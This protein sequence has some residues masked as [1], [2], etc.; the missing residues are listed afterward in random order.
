MKKSEALHKKIIIIGAGSA[1]LSAQSYIKHQTSDYLIIDKGPLGTTC[2]RVGC[3]PSKSLIEA[4]KIFYKKKD[5]KKIGI[6]NSIKLKLNS[7]K[8]FDHVRQL[9]DYFSSGV[10]KQTLE[11]PQKNFI[12][13]DAIFLDTRTIK[14]K[15]KTYT[16]DKFIIASGSNAFIPDEW[17]HLKKDLL[18]SDDIFKLKTLP[19]TL[20]VV[21]AGPIGLEL[22]LALSYLGVKVTVYGSHRSLGGL[23]DPFLMS[24]AKKIFQKN[25]RLMDEEVSGIKKNSQHKI[26]IKTQNNSKTFDKVLIA[27]GRKPNL[28]LLEN[29]NLPLKND[30]PVINDLTGQIKNTNLYIAGDMSGLHPLLHEAS[31]DGIRAAKNALSQKPVKIKRPVPL[32]IT[33]TN[34]QIAIIGSSYKELAT[35]KLDFE[36]VESSFEDQG[37]SRTQFENEGHIRIYYKRT[38]LQILGAELF[39]HKAEHLAHFLALAVTHKIS[40]DKILETPIYHPVVEEGLR[41]ALRKALKK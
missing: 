21:G 9:T 20:A 24:Y 16:A 31:F 22:A 4:A 2:A 13:A 6:Q 19:K 15:N 1:G 30:K 40:I 35:K 39:T 23:S 41:T 28:T 34:P 25:L 3:M 38:S 11:I 32:K 18:I 7:K 37:R 17:L 36:I 14:V 5:F 33:F 10:V 26:N 29:L 8:F 27:T 12:Q